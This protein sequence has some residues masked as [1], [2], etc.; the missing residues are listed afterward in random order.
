MALPLAFTLT[1]FHARMATAATWLL[2]IAGVVSTW[3]TAVALSHISL[4]TLKSCAAHVG[5]ARVVASALVGACAAIAGMVTAQKV[6]GDWFNARR[7]AFA[8]ADAARWEQSLRAIQSN[9]FCTRSRCL[10]P[11]CVDLIVR[12]GPIVGKEG[13]GSALDAANLPPELN[14]PFLKV[15]GRSMTQVCTGRE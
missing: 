1:D 3:L 6:E 10:V 13:S 14:E 8:T 15:Y 7:Q 5:R 11:I 2:L 12:Y 9:W 4:R